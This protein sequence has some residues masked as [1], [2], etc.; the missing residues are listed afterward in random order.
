MCYGIIIYLCVVTSLEF[1]DLLHIIRLVI[2]VTLHSADVALQW[3]VFFELSRINSNEFI[4][5]RE[6]FD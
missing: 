6:S 1:A 4:L 2:G 5:Y 3:I